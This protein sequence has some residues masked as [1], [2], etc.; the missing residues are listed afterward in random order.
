MVDIALRLAPSGPPIENSAGAPFEPGTGARLR[1]AEASSTVG[2]TTNV[3]TTVDQVL[4]VQLAAAP[5]FSNGPMTTSLTGPAVNKNYRATLCCDVMSDVTNAN[6]KVTIGIQTSKDGIT[7]TTKVQN[8]HWLGATTETTGAGNA[9]QCRLDLKLQSGAA[10]GVIAGDAEL[11]VRGIIKADITGATVA[12]P[13][14][15]G[16]EAGVGSCYIVLEE[17]F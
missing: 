14:G 12:H 1:L 8:E 9:R 3:I 5:I 17:L 10:L 13:E 15:S 7:W 2:S 11:A 16:D 4:G 6:V